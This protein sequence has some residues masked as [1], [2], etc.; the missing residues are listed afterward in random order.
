MGATPASSGQQNSPRPQPGTAGWG[1][2]QHDGGGW[3]HEGVEQSPLQGEPAAGEGESRSAVRRGPR[4][5][6]GGTPHLPRGQARGRTPAVR[7]LVRT[8]TLALQLRVLG[9]PG[10]SV[11]PI[12]DEEQA[13]GRGAPA[14]SRPA[15]GPGPCRQPSRLSPPRARPPSA[16][17]PGL[18]RRPSLQTRCPLGRS[19]ARPFTRSLS[20][21]PR[22]ST[23]PSAHSSGLAH[24]HAT[25]PRTPWTPPRCPQE[26]AAA[27][28]VSSAPAP[29]SMLYDAASSLGTPLNTRRLPPHPSPA[30]RVRLPPALTLLVAQPSPT[31]AAPTAQLGL[32]R[33]SATSC[34]PR[35]QSEPSLSGQYQPLLLP[36]PSPGT[37][38]PCRL[39]FSTAGGHVASEITQLSWLGIQGP[40]PG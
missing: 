20:P 35:P 36:H 7:L 17:S 25:P 40:W 16:H 32:L 21:A 37:H 4:P 11:T 38:G 15:E 23:W 12:T 13:Q 39:S 34:P 28:A 10:G 2:Y 8:L 29:L 5:V 30:G 31:S 14:Q 18:P 22:L 33:G 3:S 19:L 9:V 27:G 24:P 26:P 6:T 1:P